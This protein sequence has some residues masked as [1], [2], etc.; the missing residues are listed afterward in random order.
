MCPFQRLMDWML[1]NT[2]TLKKGK[3][4][5]ADIYIKFKAFSWS[6]QPE[7][8]CDAAVIQHLGAIKGQLSP[9]ALLNDVSASF[10]TGH[11]R[12][13]PAAPNLFLLFFFF[14]HH[15]QD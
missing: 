7:C 14:E 13:T 5:V 1:S 2:E 8:R 15:W 11:N 3:T 6:F 9:G 12:N 4:H 10:A